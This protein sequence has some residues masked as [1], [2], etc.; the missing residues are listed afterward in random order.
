MSIK[1]D[2]FFHYP[3]TTRTISLKVGYPYP[4]D[5]SIESYLDGYLIG[6]NAWARRGFIFFVYD[7][8]TGKI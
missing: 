8:N 7:G 3:N 4:L 5:Q 1:N 2:R 6:R